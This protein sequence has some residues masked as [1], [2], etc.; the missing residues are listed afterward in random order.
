MR[1]EAAIDKFWQDYLATLLQA[2]RPDTYTA[3]SFGDNPT[4][5]S[6]CFTGARG[7]E[8]GYMWRAVGV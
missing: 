3:W 2:G 5:A 6:D 1:D 4:L 8:D 7:E